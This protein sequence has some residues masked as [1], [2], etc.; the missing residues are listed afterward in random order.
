MSLSRNTNG[1]PSSRIGCGKN[2]I[3]QLGRRRSTGCR[4][5]WNSTKQITQKNKNRTARD[6]ERGGYQTNRNTALCE[7]VLLGQEPDRQAAK[8]RRLRLLPPAPSGSPSGGCASRVPFIDGDHESVSL[9]FVLALPGSRLLSSRRAVQ[10]AVMRREISRCSSSGVCFL[11][12]LG[13]AGATRDSR[14]SRRATVRSIRLFSS[15]SCRRVA[16]TFIASI[17][18]GAVFSSC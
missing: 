16:N 15:Y 6:P 7:K 13:L 10:Y 11:T 3:A 1:S 2:A 12:S 9:R 4:R 5:R 8:S 14:A 18:L 17:S